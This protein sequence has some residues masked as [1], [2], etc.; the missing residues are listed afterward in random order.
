MCRAYADPFGFP[1]AT[2]FAYLNPRNDLRIAL[3]NIL[4]RMLAATKQ[5]I[6]VS[7]ATPLASGVYVKGG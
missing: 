4:T 2:V 3:D 6:Q 7:V 5:E 1:G